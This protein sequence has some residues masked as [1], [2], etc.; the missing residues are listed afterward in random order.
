MEAVLCT[1][2]GLL[3]VFQIRDVEKRFL[4]IIKY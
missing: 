4:M 1:K 3:E 2:Y